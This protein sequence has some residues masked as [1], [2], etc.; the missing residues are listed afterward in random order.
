[1]PHLPWLALGC[2]HPSLLSLL[3]QAR[4]ASASSRRTAS[5]VVTNPSAA[6][7]SSTCRHMLRGKVRDERP[8]LSLLVGSPFAARSSLLLFHQAV[9]LALRFSRSK[10]LAF[11]DC[12]TQY[13]LSGLYGPMSPILAIT[14]PFIPGPLF[15]HL[16]SVRHHSHQDCRVNSN[17]I[18]RF[19][20]FSTCVR[21]A[22]KTSL[23]MFSALASLL[24]SSTM[25]W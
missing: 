14:R 8:T 2:P 25:H 3:R 20:A 7:Y 17:G 6:R 19:F 11:W 24:A 15:V 18:E 23:G 9:T 21:N 10:S 5:A 1:M 4:S 16:L 12:V 13:V 22:N